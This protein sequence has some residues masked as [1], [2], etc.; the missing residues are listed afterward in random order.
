LSLTIYNSK[1]GDYGLAVG[2]V[3]W[4]I[5]IALALGYFV[6]LY[7]SFRGKVALDESDG[8]GH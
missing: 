4:S 2:L 7:R 8:Y 3:W 6:Y 5:G 1:A